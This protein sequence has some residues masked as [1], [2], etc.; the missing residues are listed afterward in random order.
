[1]TAELL[2]A[3]AFATLTLDDGVV[4]YRRNHEPYPSIEAAR[5]A[6]AAMAKSLA[7][8]VEGLA[9]LLDAR[10]AVGRNDAGFEGL[11]LEYRKTL[12][13]PFRKT[14]VLVRTAVGALQT[15]RLERSG[16]LGTMHVF[17]DESEAFAF[18][19]AP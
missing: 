2:H 9:L 6:Y 15:N 12:F 17:L 3:D 13:A 18:L 7:G 14:A 11:L 19:R 4:V 5:S 16:R 1:M 8:R 10:D